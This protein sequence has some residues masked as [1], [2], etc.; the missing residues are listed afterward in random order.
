MPVNVDLV[1]QYQDPGRVFIQHNQEGL[2][3]PQVSLPVQGT[4]V[5]STRWWRRVS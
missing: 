4:V 1:S 5:G 2:L 3:A